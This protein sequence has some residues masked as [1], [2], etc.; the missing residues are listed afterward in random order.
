MRR[1]SIVGVAA[2]AVGVAGCSKSGIETDPA[3]SSSASSGRAATIA[4][5]PTEATARSAG[6]PSD[7]RDAPLFQKSYDAEAS[8]KMEDAL[9][10]LD[11]VHATDASGAAYVATLRRAWLLYRLGKLDESIDAYKRASDIASDAI[12]PKVGALA[13]LAAMRRWNDVE[14]IARDVLKR[15]PAN[16][17]ANIR[18][19]F[20][21]YS[22]ARFAEAEPVYRSLS[23]LYPSDVEVRDGL[24][25]SLFEEGKTDEASAQFGEVLAVAPQNALANDGVKALSSKQ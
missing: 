10:A 3:V 16:Y 8:G 7:P 6:A 20:A 17:T 19:A 4:Q 12:E 24:A 13:P 1:W 2:V 21:L 15:D 11:G 9:A 22:Q 5:A 14:S 18:L 23:A 25:W